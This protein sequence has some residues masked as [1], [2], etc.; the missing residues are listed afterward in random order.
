MLAS[1]FSLK[2]E[3]WDNRRKI[4]FTKNPT[5]TGPAGLSRG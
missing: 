3:L 2:P 1:G 5:P 4:H